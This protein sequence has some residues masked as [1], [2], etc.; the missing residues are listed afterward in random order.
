MQV[1]HTGDCSIAWSSSIHS[2]RSGFQIYESFFEEFLKSHRDTIDDEHCF[3]SQTGG[4]SKRTIQTLKD[5][6]QHAF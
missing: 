4:Q 5:M 2:I 3:L 1:V 6:L